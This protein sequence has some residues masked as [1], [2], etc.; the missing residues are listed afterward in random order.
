VSHTRNNQ[1]IVSMREAL[2]ARE[3]SIRSG[4]IKRRRAGPVGGDGP[5]PGG[6]S[7]RGSRSVLRLGSIGQHDR[8]R[9][10][11]VAAQ[12][13]DLEFVARFLVTHRRDEAGAT[14]DRR[15]F[16]GDQQESLPRPGR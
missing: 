8:D 11:L 12:D 2:R 9:D 6:G 5:L 4:R 7:G 13:L 10:D 16:D 14:V 15:T 3:T 1:A